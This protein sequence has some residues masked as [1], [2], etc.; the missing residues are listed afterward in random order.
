MATRE[1]IALV[2]DDPPISHQF[3]GYLEQA[4]YEVVQYFERD[5]A[6]AGIPAGSFALVVLD[7]ELNFEQ[8]A[9]L[10]IIHSL[11]TQGC[12]VPILVVSHLDAKTYKDI[13][14]QLGVWDYLEKSDTGANE[15]VSAC[16]RLIDEVALESQEAPA[17]IRHGAL[18]IDRLNPRNVFWKDR[19]L[20]L[21]LTAWK[22]L[23]HLVAH[24]GQA[25]RREEL[26]KLMNY[27][28]EQA[29]RVHIRTLRADF[30][31]V[32]PSFDSIQAISGVGYRWKNE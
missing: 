1:R 11:A 7:I 13:T 23:N 18:V 29:L 32:D 15:L 8:N 28:R 4:G 27:G 21:P 12:D 9:G 10:G 25:V 26:Y 5:A 3:K 22:L 20:H 24:A 2:E 14:S 30:E 31:A 16:R 19:R 17:S 6:R